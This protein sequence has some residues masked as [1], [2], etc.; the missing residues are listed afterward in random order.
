[1]IT[2]NTYYFGDVHRF[3]IT[4]ELPQDPQMYSGSWLNGSVW[5]WL[6][7]HCIG[8]MQYVVPLCDVVLQLEYINK[9]IS[10]S[11]NENIFFA[12]AKQ[13]LRVIMNDFENDAEDGVREK[14]CFDFAGTFDF[15]KGFD[16]RLE[17]DIM[18]D[19]IILLLEHEAQARIIIGK[20]DENKDYYKF[21]SEHI[22]NAG[23]VQAVFQEAFDWLQLRYQQEMDNERFHSGQDCSDTTFEN[24]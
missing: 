5:Y 23:E 24:M 15:W 16:I 13:I 14:N 17:M 3:G 4:F 10:F 12:D 20:I 6:S 9:K 22:L 21:Q 1:M 7:G 19:Y 11:C 18:E 8:N 2:C